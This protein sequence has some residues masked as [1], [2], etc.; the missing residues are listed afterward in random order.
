MDSMVGTG[1]N[2]RASRN[3][4]WHQVELVILGGGVYDYVKTACGILKKGISSAKPMA[5]TMTLSA[6]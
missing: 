3:L 6:T 1:L 4:L 5:S 2:D